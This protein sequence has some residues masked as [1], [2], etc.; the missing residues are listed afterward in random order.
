MVEGSSLDSAWTGSHLFKQQ[1]DS[2]TEIPYFEKNIKKKKHGRQ[3]I[4]YYRHLEPV[5][6]HAGSATVGR[7]YRRICWK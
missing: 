4:V 7:V 6:N 2:V 3:I 5:L 1:R